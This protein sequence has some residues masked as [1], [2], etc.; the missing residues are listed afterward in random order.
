MPK[1]SPAPSKAL[2]LAP[3]LLC[4]VPLAFWSARSFVGGAEPRVVAYSDLAS[5]VEAGHVERAQLDTD[6]IVATLHGDSGK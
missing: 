4:L 1:R 3:I 2:A 6:R 5:E